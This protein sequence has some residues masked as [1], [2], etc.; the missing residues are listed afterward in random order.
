M[1]LDTGIGKEI[2]KRTVVHYIIYS[3]LQWNLYLV[4]GTK[5]SIRNRVYF[6]AV[7]VEMIH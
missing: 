3:T 2:N 6:S 1:V 4:F 7:L 5:N